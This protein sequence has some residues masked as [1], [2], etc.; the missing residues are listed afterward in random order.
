MKELLEQEFLKRF[1]T[2]GRPNVYFA[3][4]RVNLIGEHIDYSGG[5]VFPCA[6]ALGTYVA[7]RRRGDGERIFQSVGVSDG[8]EKYPQAVLSA[9]RQAGIDFSGGF[10]VL[11]A[12]DLPLGA[13]LS[14]SASLEVAI[15]YA[16][17]DMFGLGISNKDIALLCQKAENDFVGV[18]CGIMDQFA[19]AMGKEGCAIYLDT[20]SLKYEHI[21]LAMEE[22]ELLILDTKKSR[23]LSE[24][25]YNERRSECERALKCLQ[26]RLDIE[27]LCELTEADFSANAELIDD[28]VCLR[29]A[30]HAVF[31]NRRVEEAVSLLG[32]GDMAA[33]GRLM[34]QSHFSLRDDYEVSCEELDVLTDILRRQDG[35]LG[36]RM[37][38]AGFGGCVVALVE[39]DKAEAVA[40]LTLE[41]YRSIIG[42]EGACYRGV[43]GAP[44]RI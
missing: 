1:G 30:R 9:M 3:G 18:S 32:Q 37:T 16:L 11:V 34:N 40:L 20:H 26:K 8:W 41:E 36:A 39:R 21:P 19:V 31:E 17:S 38:G 2:G 13:G 22:C 42:H 12:G 44:K 15:A 28:P 33:F 27:A 35:V 23:K 14:S 10:E 5:K 4:G 43:G 29:R 6:L 25:K 24:S 7:V